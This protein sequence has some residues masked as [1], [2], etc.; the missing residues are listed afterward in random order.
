MHP[1]TTELGRR[2]RRVDR[3]QIANAA[4]TPVSAEDLTAAAAAVG[5]LNDAPKR[6]P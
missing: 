2:W 3:A 4:R 5:R 6:M 1:A